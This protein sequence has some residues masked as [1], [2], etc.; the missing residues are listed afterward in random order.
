[1][2]SQPAAAVGK[3]SV[4]RS[5]GGSMGGGGLRVVSKQL[6]QLPVHECSIPCAVSEGSAGV[7][8]QT[9]VAERRERE[10]C[11]SNKLCQVPIR[12]PGNDSDA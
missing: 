11:C 2:K 6:C 12:S 5:M 1:V 7:H 3:L 8:L 4:L 9:A 10:M